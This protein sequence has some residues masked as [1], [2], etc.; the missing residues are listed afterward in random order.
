MKGFSDSKLVYLMNE[1]F[2]FHTFNILFYLMSS[3]VFCY[4]N[5][6]PDGS[7]NDKIK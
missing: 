3:V 7:H 2:I 5:S 1:S 4:T 6:Y